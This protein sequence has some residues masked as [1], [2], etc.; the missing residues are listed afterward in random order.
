[1]L[2]SPL[3]GSLSSVYHQSPLFL[4]NLR[5]WSWLIRLEIGKFST[6]KNLRPV[7]P[8]KINHLWLCSALLLISNYFTEIFN[9]RK[10]EF[11]S[12][13]VDLWRHNSVTTGWTWSNAFLSFWL[14]HPS[15]QSLNWKI[16]L[17]AFLGGSPGP[18]VMG[19][20]W[21]TEGCVFEPQHRTLD[22]HYSH[23]FFKNC[24]DVCLKINEKQTEDGQF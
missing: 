13:A 17:N 11:Y 23:F 21:Q 14:K 10:R 7:F 1:M 2:W 5:T 3:I 19:W 16:Y 8:V 20:D 18:V 24:I 9:A 4:E 22:R 15:T 6:E 12:G